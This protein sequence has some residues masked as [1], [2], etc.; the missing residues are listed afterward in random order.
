MRKTFAIALLALFVLPIAS[1]AQ[2][3]TGRL[4][5][6]EYSEE[7]Q[8]Y[9]YH[10]VWW[11][12]DVAPTA[13]GHYSLVVD[14]YYNRVRAAMVA[15]L[16]CQSPNYGQEAPLI[17]GNVLVREHFMRIENDVWANA[18]CRI[19][20]FAGSSDGADISYRMRVT[21]MAGQRPGKSESP[22]GQASA[23]S[24]WNGGGYPLGSYDVDQMANRVL[25]AA[26]SGE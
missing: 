11:S 23:A 7:Y 1:E 9:H 24:A 26:L 2:T 10:G 5:A 18:N 20:L 16:V 14:L 6:R 8:Q 15:L 3:V 21:G 13:E 12:L 17:I 19:G 22:F 4:E 25:A